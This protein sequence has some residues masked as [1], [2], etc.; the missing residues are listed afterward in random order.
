MLCGQELSKILQTSLRLR[1]L[2]GNDVMGMD[3]SACYD[4]ITEDR[5]DYEPTRSAC[6]NDQKSDV[7]LAQHAHHR[8]EMLD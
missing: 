3:G 6:W 5:E 1:L 4:L 8:P 2:A 7:I